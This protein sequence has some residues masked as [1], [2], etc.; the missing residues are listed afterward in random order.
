MQAAQ[1]GTWNVT[2]ISG[3]V[4]LPT[5]AA[6]A[7]KQ[8]ALGTAGSASSDVITIQGIASMTAVQ[9]SD[10]GGSLTIDGTVAATQSGNWTARIADGTGNALTS[11]APGAERAL[12]VAIVD[13]SGNQV[14]SFGGSGGT[15]ATDDA[16]FTAA[17][18][19][20]TPLMGFAT[21]DSV[22]SGDVGVVAM[23]T[24]RELKVNVS[25]GSLA[26]TNAGTF[27][28][29]ENGAALTSLQLI[30]NIVFTEDAA[31]SS[32]DSGVPVLTVRQDTIASSTSADGD[33]QSAK[34]N[35]VGALYTSLSHLGANAVSTGNGTAGTGVQRVAICSDNTAFSVNATLQASTNTQEVVGDAA[36]DAA[37]AGNPLRIA[38]RAITADYTS[39]A[40][41]DTAD[42]VTTLNGH[43]VVQPYSIPELS[44]S[45]A[46]ASGGITNTTG[47][48]AKTAAGAGIRNYI[49]G[50]DVVNGHATVSTDVQIRDGASGTVLWRGFAQAAGGG[51]SRIFDPPL[52]GGANTLVEVACGTTGTATY[53]N[54]T[55]YTGP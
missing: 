13:G 32:G 5:G 37:I 22:D 43:L 12:S 29:Q 34:T 44:W 23:T 11:K 1:S 10:G 31:A 30:D 9:V 14:T 42:L 17:S 41:G 36:H 8:P 35:S 3:T 53:F 7:A 28:T 51:V 47:V 55:G 39:V 46:A 2:N 24:S 26:V 25:S 4:S 27:V 49:T 21:S 52:R 20:G 6:T 18:G 50:V 15:S 19:S 38:G 33:Y 54:L 16:A 45:Y 48:T 40:S